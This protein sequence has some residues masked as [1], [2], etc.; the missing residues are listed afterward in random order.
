[1]IFDCRNLNLCVRCPSRVTRHLSRFPKHVARRTS[2]FERGQAPAPPEPVPFARRTILGALV[3][4]LLNTAAASAAADLSAREIMEKNFHVTK[5]RHMTSDATMTLINDK[6]QRRVRKT[7]SVSM[8]Q[9][10]G[11]DSKLLIRFKFPGDVEGTGYLQ[12]QHHE[13][14]DDMWIYL[15]ALKK[16][17]RLVANN[18]KDSFVG[19]DFSYGDILLPVVDTYRHKLVRSERLDGEDCWVIESVPASDQI[20]KD[21]GYGGKTSWIRK[22]NFMEKKVEFLDTASRPLKTMMVSE[23]KEVDPEHHKWWAMHRE[24]A[25]HQTGH[26]T[27]LVTEAVDASGPVGDDFFTTRYLEREK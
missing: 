18:K 6:G 12:I 8:L 11:I 27:T 9:P 4:A 13:G 10:N 26:R 3:L 16:V 24:V 22:S 25:N 15:P 17:R 2:N 1:M 14:D 7:H 23:V 19:S 5:I 20:K 21:H